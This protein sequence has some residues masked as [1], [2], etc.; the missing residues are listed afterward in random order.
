MSKIVVVL[1]F[2]I[3]FSIAACSGTESQPQQP[4]ISAPSATPMPAPT[5]TPTPVPTLPPTP[6]PSPTPTATF[7]PSPTPTPTVIPKTSE[8]YELMLELINEARVAHGVPPV[9]M[10]DNR[11][12]QIH[13][14]NSLAQCISSHWGIDGLTP[15]MRYSL[16]GGYQ[17]ENENASGTDFCRRLFQGYT[18]ILDISDEVRDSMRVWMQS[19]GHSENILRPRQRKVNIGMAWD[20][21]NFVVYLHFEG[22]YVEYTVL[23]AI[24][25]GVLSL[26]GNTK[27][28]AS[29][30]HGDH[31]RVIVYYS[32]PPEELTQG[33]IA[34]TYSICWGRKVAHL[35]YK[36]EG[37][38]ETTRRSCPTPYD[39]SP[40]LP[41]PSSEQESNEF[42][43]EAKQRYEETYQEVDITSRKIKMDTYEVEGDRFSIRA[44]LSDV[45]AEHGSGVYEVVLFGVLNGEIEP[46]SE[47]SIFHD[48][49]RPTGYEAVQ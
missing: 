46:I 15:N 39:I 25:D 49:P 26:E 19:E 29:I 17:S 2:A 13:A 34:R 18:P 23:P 22:D 28:G 16:A 7:V 38:V 1:A 27:N 11:A 21:F 8:P 24:E 5:A 36:S 32:P 35:S 37:T 40:E 3:L 33:Q 10:G 14:D 42:Y 43:Q 4:I 6:L 47:Y 44:D 31:F 45:L 30:L 41:G 20:L 48:I 9:V 12:A